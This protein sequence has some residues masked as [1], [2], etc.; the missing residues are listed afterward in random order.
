[1]SSHAKMLTS[2]LVLQL[3]A[4]K[5][6]VTEYHQ[7]TEAYVQQFGHLPLSREPVVAAHDARI[8]LR[9]LPSLAEGCVVSEVILAATKKYCGENM[10]ATSAD[11]L[12][13]FLIV[14]QKDVKTVE[15]RVHALF[16]LDAS[17]TYA[18]HKKE[19][20]SRF[21]GKQ[22]YYLLVK[23]LALSCSYKDETSKA[24]TELLLLVLKKNLPSML[25]TIKTV[26]KNLTQ[27]KKVMKGKSNKVLL[28]G[29][30][31]YYRKQIK[32]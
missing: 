6:L 13:R 10:C 7:Q 1:M 25:F 31:D 17:L 9:S 28:Q 14:S 30:M 22:G 12:E 5:A 21:E 19:M 26:I 4:V 11:H 18:Q 8:A 3:E 16:V 15:D 27:Y 23:W 29:V 20:Q 32:V 2:V 24:F